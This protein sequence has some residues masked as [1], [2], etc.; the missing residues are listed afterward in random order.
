M[1]TGAQVRAARTGLRWSVQ[2][3]ATAAAI[4]VS[5]IK[6][7]ELKDGV[8]SISA[9]NLQ[10]VQAALEAAGIEFVGMPDDGPGIRIRSTPNG[11]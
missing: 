9:R 4:S 8:P 10:S 11:G 6:R 7:L 5:T 2:D 3:L 1:L